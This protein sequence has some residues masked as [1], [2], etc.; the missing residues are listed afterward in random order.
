M[1]L[2]SLAPGKVE[3]NFRHV[4]FKRILVTDGWGISCEIALT[5]LSVD[6]TDD[7]STLIQ[8]MAWCRQAPSHYLIYLSQCWPRSVSLYDVI[9]PQWVKL[10]FWLS[11]MGWVPF[12][13]SCNC[14]LY[15][16]FKRLFWLYEL[17]GSFYPRYWDNH[18][19][20]NNF[21]FGIHFMNFLPGP[22]LIT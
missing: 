7:Q 18:T 11:C 6:F 19:V 12:S 8:V 1:R 10:W 15:E 9:R 14:V 5:R 13:P 20:G 17:R 4:I 2:N 21:T 16:L 3:R 22:S